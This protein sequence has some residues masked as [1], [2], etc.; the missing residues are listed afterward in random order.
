MNGLKE[1]LKHERSGITLI[2][3]VI[4]I[5]VL[6]ILAGVSIAMLTGDNGILTQANHAKIETR[7]GTVE[8]IVNLWKNDINLGEYTDMTV[9]TEEEMLQR[10]LNEEYVYENEID[11]KNKIIKIGDREI[12]YKIDI[13][14]KVDDKN[15][16]ELDG[17]GSEESPFL[18]QSIEDLVA[19][20]DEVNAGNNFEG[21]Y[22][23]LE[24]TL[25]FSSDK[26]YALQESLKAGGLKDEL[27]NGKGFTPIGKS[28]NFGRGYEFSGVFL[29]NDKE[30]RNLYINVIT[31]Y[32]NMEFLKPGFFGCNSGY[33][34]NLKV[35]GKIKGEISNSS[36]AGGIC[37][38]NVGTINAC[39]NYVEITA[40]EDSFGLIGGICG[41]NWNEIQNCSNEAYLENNKDGY[42]GGICGINRG[43]VTNCS[44]SGNILSFEAGGIC[45]K[46]YEGKTETCVNYGRIEGNTVGGIVARNGQYDGSIVKNCT[47]EGEVIGNWGAGGIIGY[48]TNVSS[49]ENST[50]NGKITINGKED[51][52]IVGDIVGNGNTA[53]IKSCQNNGE[54]LKN[55]LEMEM[56]RNVYAGGIIGFNS[57]EGEP[58]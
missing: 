25:D 27:T 41:E 30:I 38:K 20:S 37:G 1:K 9:E 44:N 32:D 21:Q 39:T 35:T 23:K 50:N 34:E 24:L 15:P 5:I 31:D 49:V 18:I 42:M 12:S 6:L 33:I 17:E 52:I 3:L 51:S 14:E 43:I 54:I 10:I 11:R 22:V 4:T 58:A 29:G 45:G 40:I 56:E 28:T 7:A 8:E 48:N 19:F 36:S 13:L 55:N 57:K 46:N 2:A 26:S 53:N 16:E 47:N